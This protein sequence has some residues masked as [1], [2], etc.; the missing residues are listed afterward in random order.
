MNQRI[1]TPGLASG[2]THTVT[3]VRSDQGSA[4]QRQNGTEQLSF[5]TVDRLS[6]AMTARFTY[7]VSPHAQYAAWFDWASH[8]SRAPGR[9]LELWLQAFRAATRLVQFVSRFALGPAIPP[10]VP[11]E[12]DRRF[13]DPAWGSLPMCSGSRLSS[14]RR[15]GGVAPRVRS[16]AWRQEMPRVLAS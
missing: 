5:D 15:T 1:P 10:F 13:D 9:Q 4:R 8:L 6:R 16:A 3:G 14:P 7:G 2:D 12:S 11:T